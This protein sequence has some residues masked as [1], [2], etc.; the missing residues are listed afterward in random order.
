MDS[1]VNRSP[2][3]YLIRSQDDCETLVELLTTQNYT[4]INVDTDSGRGSVFVH[5][6]ADGACGPCV[7]STVSSVYITQTSGLRDWDPLGKS[8]FFVFL[9]DHHIFPESK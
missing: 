6:S 5:T 4:K 9:N 7:Q 3:I 8:C 1:E 2:N